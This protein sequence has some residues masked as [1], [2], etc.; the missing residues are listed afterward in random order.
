[1]IGS[2]EETGG[3]GREGTGNKN[4]INVGQNGHNGH[5]DGGTKLAITL[6]GTHSMP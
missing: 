1:M 3:E 2:G 4:S 6:P 5:E